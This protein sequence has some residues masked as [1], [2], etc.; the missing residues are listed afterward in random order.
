[1]A[2][3]GGAEGVVLASIEAYNRHDLDGCMALLAPDATWEVIGMGQPLTLEELGIVLWQY[4]L[5]DVRT[6][7]RSLT[8][9]GALVAAEYVQTYTDDDQQR[10]LSAPSACFYEVADG[11]IARVRQYYHPSWERAAGD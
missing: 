7:V 5:R 3:T 8:T 10:R 9:V 11:L 4:F 2:G 6:E 1:M